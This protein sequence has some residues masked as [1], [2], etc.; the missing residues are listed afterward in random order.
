MTRGL[1]IAAVSVVVAST[2]CTARFQDSA[3]PSCTKIDTMVLMAQSVPTAQLVPCIR[4]LPAGW[5]FG[6]MDIRSG[7]STFNL[8][9]DRAGV[10]AVRVT[11][12]EACSGPR[13]TEV[14]S[15]EPATRR[16]ER[17]D[18]LMERYSGTRSYSFSGGCV[19]YRFRFEQRGTALVNDVTLA[20][21]FTE[22]SV[23]AAEVARSSNGVLH[24]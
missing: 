4:A 18:S 7:R 1:V 14:A 16:Y 6:G 5:A 3:A 11:M 9:S 13:G 17:I 15:D 2:A 8:D 19:T 10:A 21:G 20:L 24:L 23:L 22:R 12:T